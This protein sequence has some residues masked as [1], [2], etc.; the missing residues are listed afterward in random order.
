MTILQSWQAAKDFQDVEKSEDSF[1]CQENTTGCFVSVA[2][3]AGTAVFAKEWANELT[4]WSILHPPGTFSEIEIKNWLKNS[5]EGLKQGWD[6]RIPP[7]ETLPYYGKIKYYDG[8][9]ATLLHAQ[10]DRD[11]F[12]AFAIGDTCLFQIRNQELVLSFPLKSSSDFGTSTDLLHTSGEILPRQTA[13]AKIIKGEYKAGD[14]FLFATDA[15]S[16]W[17]LKCIET[18][19]SSWVNLL[20]FQSQVEFEKFIRDLHSKK[21]IRNDDATLVI[22]MTGTWLVNSNESKSKEMTAQIVDPSIVSEPSAGETDLDKE[23]KKDVIQSGFENS[24][25]GQNTQIEPIDQ[26]LTNSAKINQP[27]EKKINEQTT[28]NLETKNNSNIPKW[29]FF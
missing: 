3:G 16:C 21:A 10:L 12:R 24:S 27:L 15:L 6:Q 7:F 22:I 13:S 29:K 11:I 9:Q 8:S 2:D 4:S 25:I 23:K 28:D 26:T 19:D 14:I 18:Q 5:A 1:F 17:I 20:N